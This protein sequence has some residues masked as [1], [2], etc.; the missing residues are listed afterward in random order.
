M[1]LDSDWSISVQLIL[2]RSAKIPNDKAKIYNNSAN[3]VTNVSDWLTQFLQNSGFFLV[4]NSFFKTTG[5][6][7]VHDHCMVVILSRSFL[8]INYYQV[9]VWFLVKFWKNMHS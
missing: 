1:I 2:N 7:C 9:M 8:Y 6:Y 3:F 4:R 5:N